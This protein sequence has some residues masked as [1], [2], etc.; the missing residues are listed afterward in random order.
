MDELIFDPLP[1]DLKPSVIKRGYWM[2]DEAASDY[3]RAFALL[4]SIVT[5]R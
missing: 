4:V 3:H 5:L 2:P 1:E